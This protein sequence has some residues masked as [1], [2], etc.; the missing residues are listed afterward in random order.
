MHGAASILG[1]IPICSAGGTAWP[2]HLAERTLS[3]APGCSWTRRQPCSSNSHGDDDCYDGVVQKVFNMKIQVRKCGFT[4]ELFEQSQDYL[5]HL[6]HLRNHQKKCRVRKRIVHGWK[7]ELSHLQHTCTSLEELTAWLN[8]NF[9]KVLIFAEHLGHD[10][11][12]RKDVK[13]SFQFHGMQFSRTVSNSHSHPRNGVRNWEGS[14]NKPRGYPGW[15]GQIHI[16][17]W[18]KFQGFVTNYLELMDIYAG[19]G[20]SGEF[21]VRIYASD[22]PGIMIHKQLMGD[23]S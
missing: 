3:S 10:C 20:G 21:S 17:G 4:G 11:R 5:L 1:M 12:Q 16:Q 23:L 14:P 2:A 19:S 15:Q 7:S 6:K 22:W 13:L 9:H 8:Q 18:Q